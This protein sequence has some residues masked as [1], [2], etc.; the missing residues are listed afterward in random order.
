MFKN[1]GKKIKA[2][3]EINVCVSTFLAG[4][5]GSI[6]AY[7]FFGENSAAIIIGCVFL[8]AV[9]IFISWVASLAMAAFGELCENVYKLNKR[10][11]GNTTDDDNRTK[12]ISALKKAQKD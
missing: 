12:T 7:L 9:G 8:G 4:M 5:T 6:I 10:I 11:G 3:A 2:F 1:A